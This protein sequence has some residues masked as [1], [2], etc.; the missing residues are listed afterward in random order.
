MVG[1][2]ATR[3]RQS[4]R[5]APESQS[6]GRL[7][8]EPRG[9]RSFSTSRVAWSRAVTTRKVAVPIYDVLGGDA[10]GL[11]PVGRLDLATSGLLILTNDTQLA[12]RLTEPERAV[13]RVYVV[14]VPRRGDA[15]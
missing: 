6:A 1:S 12:H 13:P 3:C 10:A 4:Y 15:G 2:S 7:C 11:V 5:N 9:G 14:T 8:P